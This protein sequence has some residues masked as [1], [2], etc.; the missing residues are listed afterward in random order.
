MISQT[1]ASVTGRQKTLADS[2]KIGNN[3]SR[4][5][6]SQRQKKR[7][8][9]TSTP[10][11]IEG[12]SSLSINAAGSWNLKQ[13]QQENK[14]KQSREYWGDKLGLKD[15]DML[16]VVSKNIQG[17]G[18]QAGNP[19]EDELK[20]WIVNKNIDLIGIQEI[21]VNWN[22]CNNKNRFSERIRNPAWEF[23]RYSVAFNKHDKK[24]RHQYG[25]CISL[26][27]EQVTHRISGSGADER[28]LGRWSWLLLKGKDKVLVR[29]VTVYQPN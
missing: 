25:G 15:V 9:K 29:V 14:V 13:G 7:L 5:S 20:S 2:W 21:Y 23:A 22:K 18:L 27:V 26:G 1:N 11:F 4:P 10:L 16:R 8:K 28:G 3:E 6:L 24:Y 17:L 19:K 12:Q